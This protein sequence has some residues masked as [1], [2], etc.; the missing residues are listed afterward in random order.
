MVVLHPYT[1]VTEELYLVLDA[2]HWSSALRNHVT[3]HFLA[4]LVDG[5]NL[6]LNMFSLLQTI[7]LVGYSHDSKGIVLPFITTYEKN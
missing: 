1:L 3:R 4:S 7:G 2:L 6:E 5:A